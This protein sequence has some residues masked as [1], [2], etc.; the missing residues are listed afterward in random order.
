MIN[1]LVQLYTMYQCGLDVTKLVVVV[2]QHTLSKNKDEEALKLFLD[3][4]RKRDKWMR[5]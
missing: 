5:R 2:Y 4:G 1:A 3:Q